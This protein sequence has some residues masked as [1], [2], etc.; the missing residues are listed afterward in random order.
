MEELDELGRYIYIQ[1]G[2][3]RLKLHQKYTAYITFTYIHMYC[4]RDIFTKKPSTTDGCG[5]TSLQGKDIVI[6]I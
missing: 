6:G 5:N 2:K 1:R 3:F 4:K